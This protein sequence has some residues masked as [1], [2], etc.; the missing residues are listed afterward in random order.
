MEIVFQEYFDPLMLFVI[1]FFI[2]KD[3]MRKVDVQK[4]LI[5]FLYFFIFWFSALSYYLIV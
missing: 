4:T 3:D 2:H 5:I 1:I